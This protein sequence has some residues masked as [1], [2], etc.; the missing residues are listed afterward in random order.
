MTRLP[1][2]WLSVA[3]ILSL[4][5]PDG[6]GI[7]V[8]R[9]GEEGQSSFTTALRWRRSRRRKERGRGVCSVDSRWWSELGPVYLSLHLVPEVV[10]RLGPLKPRTTPSPEGLL[11]ASRFIVRGSES[12]SAVFIL[13][14][15]V[16]YIELCHLHDFFLGLIQALKTEQPDVFEE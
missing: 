15:L 13:P 16:M 7:L 11:P 1:C 4:G 5:L 6:G 12:I 3:G 8:M 14:D 2:Y 10:T 9:A